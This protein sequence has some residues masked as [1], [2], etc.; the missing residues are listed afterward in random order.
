MNSQMNYVSA[1]MKRLNQMTLVLSNTSKITTKKSIKN[2]FKS[3]QLIMS[4]EIG[5]VRSFFEMTL[6]FM[7]YCKLMCGK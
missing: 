6:Y 1:T 2:F 7:G 3:Q 5:F 4:T